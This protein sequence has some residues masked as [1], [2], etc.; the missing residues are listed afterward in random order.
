MFKTSITDQIKIGCSYFVVSVKDR[1]IDCDGSTGRCVEQ[2]DNLHGLISGSTGGVRTL[3]VWKTKE[4]E[5]LHSKKDFGGKLPPL[6]ALFD[7]NYAHSLFKCI[8][9]RRIRPSKTLSVLRYQPL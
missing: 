6:K 1:S 7:M 5:V 4:F 9:R 3:P 2:R 8:L